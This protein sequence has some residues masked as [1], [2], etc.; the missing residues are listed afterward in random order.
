MF[1]FFL[2]GFFLFC[3]VPDT[4]ATEPLT[5]TLI[6][7]LK[8]AKERAVNVVVADEKVKQALARMSQAQA[9]L[10]PQISGST[11]ESRQTRNLEAQGISIP[12]KD[13]LV[14]P[15]NTF[16]ARIK[17]T[18]SLLDVASV[19]TLAVTSQSEALAKNQK[20]QS[21]QGA[22]ALVAS[23][24]IEAQRAEMHVALGRSL[25]AQ[26]EEAYRLAQNQLQQGS[27]TSLG[28][29]QAQAT[30]ETSQHQL[31]ALKTDEDN[32]K[33]DLLAS[34]ELSP[35]TKLILPSKQKELKFEI[36]DDTR[37]E[38]ATLNNSDLKVAQSAL[39]K[40]SAEHKAAVADFLP[41]ITAKAD[42]GASGTLPADSRSTY[43]YG[44]E[45][46]LPLIDGGLRAARVKEA[47]SH[48]L[49]NKAEL[50][51]T[52]IKTKTAIH[53]AKNDLLETEKGVEATTSALT[54]ADQE[55]KI[56]K[57]KLQSGLGSHYEVTTSI[58][59]WTR[60]ENDWHDAIAN[61]ELATLNLIYKMGEVDNF[62]ETLSSHS[63]YEK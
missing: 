40:S 58:L 46:N 28:L 6:D 12:G 55:L 42:Y 51:D 16:D 48:W 1:R 37:I 33:K 25:V 62:L 2:L 38:S 23:L 53:E 32:R 36:P 34:L 35:D 8:M 15:F 22:L 57:Q 49:E 5:L 18:Q 45:L 56:S 47:K 27:G 17:L 52:E 30:L 3:C 21:E 50:Q 19:E 54:Q 60:T 4:Q 11:S 59:Q 44:A 24:Y 63:S 20:T 31:V 13:P 26:S 9:V 43:T 41:K 7:A 10:L 14:G 39:K 29:I 61:R